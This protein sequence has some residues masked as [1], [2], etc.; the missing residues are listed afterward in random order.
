MPE[1]ERALLIDLDGV[2]Y[3]A[4][5]AIPG[6]RETIA[7]LAEQHV[8]RLFVTNTTSQ[9]RA[10]IVA[11]LAAMDIHIRESEILTPPIV[12]AA[13]LREHAAGPVALFVAPAARGEFAHLRIATAGESVAAVVVGDYGELWTFA[14]LNRAFRLLMAKPR[15]QLLALG[16]TRYWLAPDGLRLDVGP[17]VTALAHA[18]DIEPIVLGKPAMEFFA[19]A[20]AAL[21][22]AARH[23]W[24][25]G[26]DV[27]NDVRGAQDAGMRGMLVKTGK[28]RAED[29]G[30]GIEP[31]A[32]LDSIADLPSWWMTNARS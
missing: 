14:E 1:T 15:P 23:T 16:M 22:S 4:G 12:A 27:R 9:P 28:F 31:D 11:R 24:M 2:I 20:L 5:E 7:W 25:I 30:V 19:V 17:F 21:G 29:L 10:A 32:V 3:S 6:A 26:D 13:W 8:P 18:A